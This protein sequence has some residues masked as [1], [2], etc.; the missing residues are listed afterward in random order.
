MTARPDADQVAVSSFYGRRRVVGAADLPDRGDHGTGRRSNGRCE[1][2]ERLIVEGEQKNEGA[3]PVDTTAHTDAVG[4]VRERGRGGGYGLI[5]LDSSGDEVGA[6]EPHVDGDV[7][8]NLGTNGIDDLDCEAQAVL[9]RPP[10]LV[11]PVI[12]VGG[13]E[14]VDEI[15]VSEVEAERPEAGG[16]GAVPPQRTPRRCR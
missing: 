12:R 11:G 10:V 9:E 14:L 6:V 1:R 2:Q 16:H 7:L 8:A 5:D 3:R 15:A 13:E 4:T